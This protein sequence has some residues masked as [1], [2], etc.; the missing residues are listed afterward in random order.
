MT[1]PYTLRAAVLAATFCTAHAI[2][3]VDDGSERRLIFFLIALAA[4][5]A[6]AYG[7]VYWAYRAETDRSA[8]VGLYI[9]Y[10][11]VGILL[12]IAGLALTIYGKD[13]G[14]ALLLGGIGFTAPLVKSFRT[15][16]SR[17]TQIDPKSPLHMSGMSIFFGVLG[18]L[19]ATLLPS[20]E[21]HHV[22]TYC[23]PVCTDG[24]TPQIEA[25]ESVGDVQ[26][27]AQLLAWVGLSYVIVGT[28]LRRTFTEANARLGLSWPTPR[29]IAIAVGFLFIAM[30]VNGLGGALTAIFQ[31][32]TND[33]IQNS[34]E[35]LTG[36]LQNPL[37]AVL[38][39]VSAGVGEELFFR[40]ALQ[41]RFGIVLTA[42]C[43]ALLHTNY[44]LSFVTLGVFGMGF[45]F[46]IQR[47]RYG[48]VSPMITH[49]LVN[50][51]AVL[52]QT[53]A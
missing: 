25:T 7:L 26:L 41:P 50:L 10:G 49:G 5:L 16:V 24:P 38:I 31:P 42:I 23:P 32:E 46:G 37:G 14:T 4:A 17:H 18:F 43:F 51:I 28:R 12:T 39:G 53:Y 48:T 52:V 1:A 9:I 20:S 2:C 3:R 21:A 13:N 19:V 15:L 22:A 44:G 6:V 36:E 30:I 45:V 34:L 40:G 8:R 27:V 29:V 35:E 11:S 33:A 47:K